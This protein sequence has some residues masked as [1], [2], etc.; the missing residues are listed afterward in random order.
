[1]DGRMRKNQHQAWGRIRE[2]RNAVLIR[3]RGRTPKLGRGFQESSETS[4]YWPVQELV[5]A[6]MAII[7]FVLHASPRKKEGNVKESGKGSRQ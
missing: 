6:S 7:P 5:R 4:L 2:K 1:M 3:G